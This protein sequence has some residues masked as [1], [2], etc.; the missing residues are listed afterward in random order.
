M[1][2]FVGASASGKTELAYYLK[3]NYHYHKCITTTTRPKRHHETQ[4]VDYH[5]VEDHTFNTLKIKQAFVET[6][7]YYGYQYGLQKQ[8]ILEDG[9]IILDPN[10]TNHILEQ[11]KDKVFVCYVESSSLTRE[12]RMKM[13]GDVYDVIQKRIKEDDDIFHPNRLIKINYKLTNENKTFDVLAEEIHEAYQ[14]W[15]KETSSWS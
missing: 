5:F 7:E 3:K 2:I 10:G 1:L 4:D 14:K 8:D 15:K 12:N 6:N 9:L 13:R 11:Y